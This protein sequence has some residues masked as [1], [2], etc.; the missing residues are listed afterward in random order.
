LKAP[1]TEKAEASIGMDLSVNGVTAK[2][3]IPVV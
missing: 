2:Q 3:P 1:K